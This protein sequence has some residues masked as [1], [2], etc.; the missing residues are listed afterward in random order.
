[1][2]VKEIGWGSWIIHVAQDMA[3]CGAVVDT[4]MNLQV[5]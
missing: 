1:M 2:G 5:L 4:V 3:K